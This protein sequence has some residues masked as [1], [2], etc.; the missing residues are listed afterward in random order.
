MYGK[1]TAT[2]C[3]GSKKIFLSGKRQYTFPNNSLNPEKSNVHDLNPGKSKVQD[4]NPGKSKVQELNPGKSKVQDLN[5]GKSKYRN[6]E[7][8]KYRT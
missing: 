8:A 7:R 6:P 5:P 4:L 2:T 3:N 1:A